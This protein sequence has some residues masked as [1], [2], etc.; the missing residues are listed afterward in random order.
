MTTFLLHSEYREVSNSEG[1]DGDMSEG[2]TPGRGRSRRG[3]GATT[4]RGRRK[5]K[6]SGK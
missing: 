6:T 4:P 2:K 3:G 1:E 5:S